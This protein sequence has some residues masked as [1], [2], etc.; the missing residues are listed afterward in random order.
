MKPAVLVLL[1]VLMLPHPANAAPR[2]PIEQRYTPDYQRCLNTGDAAKGVTLAMLDC[3]TSEHHRQDAR[4]NQTYAAVM[5]RL[6]SA[7]KMVLRVSER[8]WLVDRDAECR[9]QAKPDEGGTIWSLTMSGCL[10]DATIQRTIWL[11]RYR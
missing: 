10:I 1:S 8:R 5:T 9:R 7:R 2:S 6:S 4:L 3:M 11:E